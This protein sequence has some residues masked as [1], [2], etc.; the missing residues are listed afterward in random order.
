M[1]KTAP[2]AFTLSVRDLVHRAGEMREH[3]LDIPARENLGDGLVSVKQGSELHLDLRLEGLHEGILVS[4]DVDA[5]ATGVCGRCLRD[6]S[7][8][9]EVEFAEL[10]AY[11]ADDA[12][13]YTVHDDH[14]DL[15][16]VVRDA[17]VLSL[18]FQPVCQPDCPGLDPETGERL[19]DVP[20]R[21]PREVLDP[22][23]AVLDGYLA[24]DSETDGAGDGAGR[25]KR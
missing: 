3:A 16:P 4:A 13:D 5:T 11:T 12:F 14:V 21:T 19:A 6:I 18:P 15:E 22:R 10:F 23:W 25:E 8:P 9:V 2:S 17:V 24:Q 20:D 7:L 1:S